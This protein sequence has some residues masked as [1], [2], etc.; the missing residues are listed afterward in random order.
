MLVLEQKFMIHFQWKAN[1]LLYFAI[2]YIRLVLFFAWHISHYLTEGSSCHV[3]HSND[4]QS[5]L[6]SLVGSVLNLTALDASITFPSLSGK[7]KNRHG[8]SGARVFQMTAGLYANFVWLSNWPGFVAQVECL[9]S[10]LPRWISLQRETTPANELTPF[11][12]MC[13]DA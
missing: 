6:S 13:N 2:H 5:L 9:R 4:L 1:K 7:G 8:Q 11:V 10:Y 12:I 3:L